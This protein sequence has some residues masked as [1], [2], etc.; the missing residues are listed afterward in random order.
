MKTDDVSEQQRR[1]QEAEDLKLQ[2]DN[3]LR[4]VLAAPAGR[5]FMWRLIDDESE[6]YSLDSNVTSYREG[7]RH[8][9]LEMKRECQRV[10][11]QSYVA[12]VREQLE[13]MEA[14]IPPPS[15]PIIEE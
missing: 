15:T 8:V 4:A 13:R 2:V 5:R 12:M 3:D 1:R 14:A 9:R 11:I 10:S 7:I 6:S